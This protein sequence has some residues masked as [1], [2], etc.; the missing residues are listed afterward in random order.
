LPEIIDINSDIDYDEVPDG[1]SFQAMHDLRGGY[2]PMGYVKEN[3]SIWEFIDISE[4]EIE[5]LPKVD[6]ETIPNKDE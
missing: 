3:D 2:F 5:S 4:D 1:D 6:R